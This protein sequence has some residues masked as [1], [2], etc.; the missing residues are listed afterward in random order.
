MRS[1]TSVIFFIL[2]VLITAVVLV[3]SGCSGK[4]LGYGVVLLSPDEQA[5]QT[6]SLVEITDQSDL[7]NTY[8]IT[9]EDSD[10]PYRIDMWRVR[11]FEDEEEARTSAM[12]YR[13]YVRLY[14]RNL[15]DG[16]AI[17]EEP[18]INSLR[19]YKMRLGQQVKILRKTGVEEE[20]GGHRGYWYQVLTSDGVEGYCFDYYLEIFDINAEP[21]VEEGPDLSELADALTRIYRPI[22]FQDMIRNR[23][24]RLDRF[25]Q[26][27]G[28]FPDPDEKTLEVRLFEKNYSFQYSSIKKTGPSNYLLLPAGVE[29]IV[30][31]EARVQLVF[32][33]EDITYDPVFI[34]LEQETIEDLRAEEQERRKELFQSILEN[35]PEYSGSAYGRISFREDNRFTWENLDRLVPGIIPDTGYRDGE[36]GFGYFLGEELRETYDGVMALYFSR[37]PSK[38][39]LFLYR[40]E[41]SSL[42]LEFLPERNVEERVVR[43]GSSSPL[44]MA[45]FKS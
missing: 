11:F 30:R 3:L 38:P 18:G 24:I 12:E 31:S 44:I 2:P 9:P 17:R 35:G 42:K 7:N 1:R 40:L 39:I 37:A 5:V 14:G 27:Y 41:E 13:D 8:G 20:I 15:R 4:A 26:A 43:S 6:G 28:L 32:T 33:E 21:K 36:V 10:A 19:V 16:L 22:V 34:Y 23:R 29:F 45:F 25:S